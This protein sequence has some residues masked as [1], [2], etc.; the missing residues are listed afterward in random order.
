M[1]ILGISMSFQQL[2]IYFVSFKFLEV[3]NS[4]KI[5]ELFNYKNTSLEIVSYTSQKFT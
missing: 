5:V 3:I 4:N 1:G 2:N